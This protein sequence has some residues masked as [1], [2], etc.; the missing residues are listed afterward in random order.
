MLDGDGTTSATLDTLTS[1][2]VAAY[3]YYSDDY[4]TDPSTG[5]IELLTRSFDFVPSRAKIQYTYGYTS[6][7]TIVSELSS[8]LAGIRA[9]VNFLGGNYDRLNSYSLPEQSYNKGDFYDRGF[10]IITELRDRADN[11]LNQLGRKQKS[12]FFVSSGGNY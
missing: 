7:P 11:L 6:A 8:C 9:W 1:G 5:L 12:Q 3:T 2:E 10:K 4:F